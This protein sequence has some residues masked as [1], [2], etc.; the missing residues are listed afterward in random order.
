MRGC[1]QPQWIFLKILSMRICP[2]R[3]GGFT[4]APAHTELSGQQ[5]WPKPAWPPCPTLSIH[6]MS[7]RAPFFV[8]LFPGLK[9]K[10]SKGNIFADVEEVKQKRA[11][12]RERRQ[13]WHVQRLFW[14]AETVLMG[15]RPGGSA[16]KVTEV[17][18]NVRINT[19]LFVPP[20]APCRKILCVHERKASM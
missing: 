20:P 17:Q 9:K 19:Q 14:A 11:E 1:I 8:C 13:N 5:F 3:D 6:R 4:G 15:Q 18:T 2:F 7:P 12:A 10:S 16:S